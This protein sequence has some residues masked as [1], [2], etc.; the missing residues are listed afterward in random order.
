[1]KRFLLPA[2]TLTAAMVVVSGCAQKESRPPNV[3]LISIDTLRQDHVSAYG[4]DRS[5]TP[6]LDRLAAEGAVFANAWSTSSWTLPSHISA[7]TGLLP[8]VHQVEGQNDRLPE[9]IATL[10]ETLA[11]ENYASAGFVSHV[12]LDGQ[13][14]FSRG[15]DEYVTRPT[16]IAEEVTEQALEWLDDHR[17]QPFFLFLHYFDPHADYAPPAGYAERFDDDYQGPSVGEYG[18][19]QRFEDPAMP[20]PDEV[21]RHVVALYDGEIRYTDD[22]IG[23]VLDR[24]REDGRLDDTI[25]AVFSDHGEE[26]KEHGSFGHGG[27]LYSEVTRVPLILRY[28]PR[29]L[30]GTRVLSASVISDLPALISSLA[31]KTPEPQ[32][33]DEPPGPLPILQELAGEDVPR[34][35]RTLI[36]ETTREGPKR[37]SV[38]EGEYA[39][40]SPSRH[41]RVDRGESAGGLEQNWI[42]IP[43]G[44][45]HID[46]D[47]LQQ[48]NLLGPRTRPFPESVV[49]ESRNA[50]LGYVRDHV[51]GL[52]LMCRGPEGRTA[53]IEGTVRF[54]A[55]VL[56]EPFG[57][58]LGED[59]KL[60][61]LGN[62]VARL[63]SDH[64]GLELEVGA[65]D[66]GVV[67]V[68]PTD[69]VRVHISLLIDGSSYH[70]GAVRIPPP[71]ETVALGHGGPTDGGCRLEGG[72]A[73]AV[74]DRGAVSLTDEQVERLR[75]LGYVE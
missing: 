21:A 63:R 9:E 56:D 14:G 6:N 40:I 17:R 8:S 35:D 5:T 64:Y 75:S 46:G 31:G 68:P 71:G 54:D 72:K 25:V 13:Y 53:K 30:P 16:Q 33:V 19:L 62:S 10:A 28:P 32:F 49:G 22:Q 59:D 2:A 60:I 37:F 12:Y 43:E 65:D 58:N 57:Y 39:Y 74:N 50:V 18:F 51:Q 61:P 45:F 41:V 27:T 7:L 26:F 73:L 70:S 55:A 48:V 36:L 47:P 15:F 66:K 38:I 29:I 20:L 44:L 69:G 67:F 3:L 52:R 34:H 1:M 42:P 11:R 24:L 4:Y 23:R